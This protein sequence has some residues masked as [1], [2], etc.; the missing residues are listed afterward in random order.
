MVYRLKIELEYDQVL[1]DLGDQR[2]RLETRIDALV[3][4]TEAK[5][6]GLVKQTRLALLNSQ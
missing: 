6:E 2:T 5:T 1:R 3:G 4:E